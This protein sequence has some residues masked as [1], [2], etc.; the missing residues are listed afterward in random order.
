MDPV[1][2]HSTVLAD[3]MIR[4]VN[5]LSTIKNVSL[6]DSISIYLEAVECDAE[7][8]DWNAQLPEGWR[9]K[10]ITGGCASCS[11]RSC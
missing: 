4:C 3:I 6:V 11:A 7:L 5:F 8:R 9:H 1:D 10:P 2:A